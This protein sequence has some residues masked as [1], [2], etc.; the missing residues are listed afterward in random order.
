MVR[1]L[2]KLTAFVF[3]VFWLPITA[4]CHL[5][6][7]PGLEFL[8]CASDTSK[9]AGCEGD[10]C[11]TVESGAYKISNHPRSVPMPV[12]CALA[13]LAPAPAERVQPA[14]GPLR[15]PTSAPP[16]LPQRWQ[17]VSR[18]ALPVRAPS[19]RS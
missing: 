8:Q 14:F 17:F 10:G 1:K 11:Q 13:Y 3:L 9:T 16:D 6:K 19:L 5:E 18:A 7:F 15:L 12:P 4:H 2:H